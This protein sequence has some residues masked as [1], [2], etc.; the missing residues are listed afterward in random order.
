MA[1]RVSLA[2]ALTLVACGGP[3]EDAARRAEGQLLC[4]PALPSVR[5]G[6]SDADAPIPRH[7]LGPIGTVAFTDNSPP[8]NPI[9][10]PGA[11]L[12]RVLF[13]DVRLSAG[14]RIACASC[15]L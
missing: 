10:N 13:Y 11:T 3:A 8:D 7:F 2:S 5:Y 1:S 12:G 15:H 6:Y 14:D 4:E 9:T